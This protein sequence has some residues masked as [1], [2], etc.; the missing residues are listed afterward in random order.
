MR[1]ETV[2][3]I[4]WNNIMFSVIRKVLLSQQH[5]LKRGLK[6]YGD[7]GIEAVMREVDQMYMMNTFVPKK[8]E[9]LTSK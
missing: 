2:P 3:E 4:N 1:G 9:D 5:S 6:I 7:R 8:F